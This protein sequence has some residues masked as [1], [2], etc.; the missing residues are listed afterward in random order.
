MVA[1]TSVANFGLMIVKM[2]DR[3][4]LTFLQNDNLKLCIENRR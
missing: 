2:I 3:V 4:E 1:K